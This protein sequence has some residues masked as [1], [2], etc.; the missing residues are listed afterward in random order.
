MNG[1]RTGRGI[2]HK[3][4]FSDPRFERI[5]EKWAANEIYQAIKRVNRH[6]AY[7]TNCYL[8]CN[9]L[10]VVSHV[11]EKLKNCEVKEVSDVNF[12]FEFRKTKQDEYVEKLQENSYANRFITLLAE[13]KNGKHEQLLH[14][15]NRKKGYRYKKKTVCE[16]LGM[17]SANF[18]HQI[19]KNTNVIQFCDIR[20][21]SISGQ[22]IV[23]PDKDIA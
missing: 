5:R 16:Y 3:W 21:I 7:S 13:L 18:S 23:I 2:T 4:Q 11:E 17:N 22:Y 14:D 1:K 8:I 6:M 10:N 19:E 20:K 12:Q 9:N 15:I